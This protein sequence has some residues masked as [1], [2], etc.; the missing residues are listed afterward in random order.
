MTVALGGMVLALAL[1]VGAAARTSAAG[2]PANDDR[3]NAEVIPTFPATVEGTT[4]GA[5]VE[6][7]DPQRSQCGTVESTVSYRINQA[8][9][10]TIE[11]A[12]RGAGLAPVVRIY[13]LAASSI[14]EL[15][16]ASAKVGAAARVAWETRR[17]ASYLVLVG[18][19]AGTADAPFELTA[20]LYLPPTNDSVREARPL[21]VPGHVKATTFGA[22]SDPSDPRACGLAGGTVWYSL[23]TREGEPRRTAASRG[24]G[25]RRHGSRRAPIALAD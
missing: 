11:L 25:S 9:D 4:V 13:N 19:R 15:D 23:A 7:L 8:P 10:G 3:A 17:G 16:C 18:K 2:P 6:R 14:V 12:V 1:A 24:G 22:T 21:Q 20:Q 5:T